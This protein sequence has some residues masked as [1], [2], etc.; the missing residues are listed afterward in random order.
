M[1]ERGM[2]PRYF[3]PFNPLPSSPFSTATPNYF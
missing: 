3:N 1:R 2:S